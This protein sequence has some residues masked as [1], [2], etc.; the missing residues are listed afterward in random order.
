MALPSSGDSFPHLIQKRRIAT[1]ICN[2]LID[3]PTYNISLKCFPYVRLNSCIWNVQAT[4]RVAQL[5]MFAAAVPRAV[6]PICLVVAV[7]LR[8]VVRALINLHLTTFQNLHHVT[9][10]STL[11]LRQISSWRQ[12]H[13]VMCHMC[14]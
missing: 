3:L 2:S 9:L 4:N 13:A 5:A 7:L 6:V 10:S 14:P 8:S 12:V 11:R 1:W